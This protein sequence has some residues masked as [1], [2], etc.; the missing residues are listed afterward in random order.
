MI[1][2]ISFEDI[3]TQDTIS[4]DMPTDI[5]DIIFTTECSE[6][7][8]DMVDELLFLN[9]EESALQTAVSTEGNKWDNFKKT[10]KDIAT[11]V[12]GFIKKAIKFLINII[13][14]PF[15]MIKKLLFGDNK[16]DIEKAKFNLSKR[17]DDKLETPVK[18][19]ADSV[20]TTEKEL[21][22]RIKTDEEIIEKTTSVI[23]DMDKVLKLIERE[24]GVDTEKM[25]N[26]IMDTV[27]AEIQTINKKNLFM[28]EYMDEL[29]DLVHSADTNPEWLPARDVL[30]NLKICL[31]GAFKITKYERDVDKLSGKMKE[32]VKNIDVLEATVA[33]FNADVGYNEVTGIIFNAMK[34]IR[35][36]IGIC[37]ITNKKLVTYIK[38]VCEITSRVVDASIY[39]AHNFPQGLGKAFDTFHSCDVYVNDI[40]LIRLKHLYDGKYNITTYGVADKTRYSNKKADPH[41]TEWVKTSGEMIAAQAEHV[42]NVIYISEGLASVKDS[43]PDIYNFVLYH[44]LTHTFTDFHTA[45]QPGT[46]GHNADETISEIMGYNAVD[47]TKEKFEQ[48][49]KWLID[50]EAPRLYR[51]W[52]KHCRDNGLVDFGQS[53]SDLQL[54][55]KKTYYTRYA[56]IEKMRKTGKIK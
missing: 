32:L 7:Y 12:I 47:M 51:V 25:I 54:A 26:G 13:T 9:R 37:A 46:H 18:D 35:T 22:P 23:S 52:D 11:K 16:S 50:T 6:T 20:K 28:K 48:C 24:T 14:W 2:K 38:D 21:G 53:L 5:D 27:N 15:R 34:V 44:E 36:E 43:H 29:T 56:V 1:A 30:A 10:V 41:G 4:R 17:P 33:K 45:K 8:M 49:M 40:E 19:I 31:D 42:V 39:N 55:W 3:V